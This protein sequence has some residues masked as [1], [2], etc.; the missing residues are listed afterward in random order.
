[1]GKRYVKNTSTTAGQ[2][3]HAAHLIGRAVVKKINGGCANSSDG[4]HKYRGPNQQCSCGALHN[5]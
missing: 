1:M 4:K 3:R 5:Q 2:A